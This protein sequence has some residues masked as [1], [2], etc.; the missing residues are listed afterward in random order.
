MRVL[1]VRPDNVEKDIQS[2]RDILDQAIAHPSKTV[3]I[4]RRVGPEIT[5]FAD[6][7]AA[8]TDPF[9]WREAVWVTDQRI[10]RPLEE[11]RYFTTHASA[12][13]SILNVRDIPVVWLDPT[14]TL[15]EVDEAFLEAE[16][17]A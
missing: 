9:P 1:S 4:I 2:A 13:G 12:S 5:R 6:K 14:A 11:A 10:F 16:S 7:V 17:G 15:P 8:R 3:M